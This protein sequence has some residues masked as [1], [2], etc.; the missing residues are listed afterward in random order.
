MKTLVIY[1]SYSGNTKL[2][3]ETVAQ[4]LHADIEELQPVKPLNASGAGYVAWGL[5]Q[6][7]SASKPPLKP[8]VHNPQ[9][10][11][12][13]VIGTPVWSY[14]Y[15][16]PVRTFFETM[17]LKGKKFAL[18][19]SHGGD[20]RKTLDK[21][22]GCLSGNDIIGKIDFCDPLKTGV[23]QNRK[24]AANWANSLKK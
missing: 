20:P 1:Y 21:M 9:E 19:C 22:A 24:K 6:L 5:R 3:A 23:E 12:L 10:Y 4:M 15:T 7:V 17:S 8:L 2:V 14:T 18:F 11:D 16:P 13:I